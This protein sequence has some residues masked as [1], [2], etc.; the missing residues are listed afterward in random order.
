M[1]LEDFIVYTKNGLYC[2]T[3]D[4]F[5]DPIKPVHK[6]VITHAHADH[7]VRGQEEIFC[8]QP[9]ADVM[10]ERYV[11]H[12]GKKFNL[13]NSKSSF[14]I[15]DVKVSFLPAGHILGSVQVLMEYD[16][17]KY[18]YT[19]DFKLQTDSTCEC[20]EYAEADV[21]IT[22]STFAE[23]NKSHPDTK[24]EIEKL[25]T[26][27]DSRIIIGSYALGKAQRLTQ[28][29]SEICPQK[30]IFIHRKIYALH[31]IYENHKINLGRWKPY[32]SQLFK[33]LKQAVYIVPPNVLSSYQ[34]RKD[35]YTAFATGWDHLQNGY[36]LKLNISDHADW[37][38][39]LAVIAK[40]KPK[41]ILTLH[42][43]GEPLKKHF[44]NSEIEVRILN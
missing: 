16:N 4:F 8:T 43:D 36:N 42:G 14:H 27:S 19:G 12:A 9:T 5:I 23:P 41:K 30:E 10:K 29:I 17:A 25:N 21:L 2:K 11:Q 1:I 39:V 40:T 28:L 34:G 6:A 20:Y 24:T 15:G 26:I 35:F 38:D 13:L 3:G 33:R 22:E 18:L 31:K 37:N 44:E 7:A 32:S